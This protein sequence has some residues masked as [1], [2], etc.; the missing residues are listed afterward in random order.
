MRAV[1]IGLRCTVPLL[2]ALGDTPVFYMFTLAFSSTIK[3]KRQRI[4]A[5]STWADVVGTFFTTQ[6]LFNTKL[7]HHDAASLDHAI[8]KRKEAEGAARSGSAWS[9]HGMSKEWHQFA[10]AW[11]EIVVSLR[12]RDMISNAERDDLIFETL[13][14]PEHKRAFAGSTY[15]VLPTMLSS[16][17]FIEERPLADPAIYNTVRGAPTRFD[18]ASRFSTIRPRRV[19][20]T[21]TRLDEASKASSPQSS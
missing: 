18:A 3:A 7:L 10:R 12:A 9:Y 6:E 14:S 5:L 4:G 21:S 20:H 16:P 17:I 19:R 2:L 13:S 15:V 11:N 1:L 8:E